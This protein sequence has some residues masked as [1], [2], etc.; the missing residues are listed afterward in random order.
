MT[1][2]A[3]QVKT[4]VFEGPFDL[5]LKAI[6][7]GKIDVYKI[8]LSQITA[9]FF[10]YWKQDQCDLLAASDF[11]FMA[12][13]LIEIKAKGLLPQKELPQENEDLQGIE[14]S[15][16]SHLEEYQLFK[17]MALDLGERKAIFRRIYSRHEGEET[18]PEVKLVDV[19]L[20]DLVVA[21][22]KVYKEA[23]EREKIVEIE[24]EEVTLD[25]RII[26]IKNILS[27]CSDGLPFE[28]LFLRKTRLE[29]VVTFLAILELAKQ[30]HI[31]I[32]Q[33]GKFGSIL[34]FGAPV[35]AERVEVSNGNGED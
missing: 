30:C 10:E 23:T 4:E 22:Q 35:G 20:R 6:D 29:I 34:I 32:K 18:E 1:E 33:E 26:E 13:C 8:S 11:L 5:L 25:Q 27:R 7:D 15:L 21:F 2:L 14:A 17:K 31:A 24:R 12:A 9:S 16:L 28:E 19:S 3:Y